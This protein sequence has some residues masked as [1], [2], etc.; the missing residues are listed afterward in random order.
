MTPKDEAHALKPCPFCGTANPTIQE[1]GER[2]YV[3][4][5]ATDCFICIGEGYD[6]DAMPDHVFTTAEEAA[7][8]WNTRAEPVN[9]P[10]KPNGKR[11]IDGLKDAVA[12]A[13]GDESKGTSETFNAP[14]QDMRSVESWSEGKNLECIECDQI[15]LEEFIRA[16]QQDAIATERGHA[17]RMRTAL[18]FY[19]GEWIGHVSVIGGTAEQIKY[20]PSGALMNDHGDKADEALAAAPPVEQESAWRD[21]RRAAKE[22]DSEK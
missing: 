19:A 8:K 12:Y 3:T 6:R 13:K 4:C 18:E 2:F 7:E 9:A 17:A 11:I 20:A 21:V 22:R 15:C 16:I 14:P 10:Q 5:A 1:G